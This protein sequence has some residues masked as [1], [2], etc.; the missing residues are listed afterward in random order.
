MS[1]YN[2]KNNKEVKLTTI[3]KEQF[4]PNTYPKDLMYS[5]LNEFGSII[6]NKQ[7]TKN[8]SKKI[9][10]R[11]KRARLEGLFPFCSRHYFGYYN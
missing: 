6:R 11:I 10:K 7:Y 5:M 1:S 2:E 9:N 4:Y 3:K 8:Q